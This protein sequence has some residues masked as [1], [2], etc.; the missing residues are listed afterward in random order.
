MENYYIDRNGK[1][2]ILPWFKKCDLATS[3]FY[4][5]PDCT[6]VPNINRVHMYKQ[7]IVR[8]LYNRLKDIDGLKEFWVFGS[9]TQWRCN[10]FS[11][12]DVAFKSDPELRDAIWSIL[13]GADP[14]GVDVIDL[15]HVTPNG[16]LDVQIWKGCRII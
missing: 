15:N 4:V 14:N 8:D 1:P 3:Y 11:D 13:C 2:A 16:K 6:G 7:R 10:Q 12:L 9:S 5:L